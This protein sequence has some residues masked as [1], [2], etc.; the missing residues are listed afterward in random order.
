[1]RTFS[2]PAN[3]CVR[4]PDNPAQSNDNDW[5][6][7]KRVTQTFATKK[8]VRATAEGLIRLSVRLRGRKSTARQF[9]S[10]DTRLNVSRF[11]PFP[12]SARSPQ[13]EIRARS[14][15]RRPR[16]RSNIFS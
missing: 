5:K 8:E 1:M 6:G 9:S 4:S 15:T 2:D 11:V 13:I 7:E 14:S 12:E 10:C 16:E 3:H